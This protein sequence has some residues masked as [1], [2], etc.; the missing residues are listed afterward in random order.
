MSYRLVSN[1]PINNLQQ[2]YRYAFIGFLLL[3]VFW[4][5]YLFNDQKKVTIIDTK[6]NNNDN[7]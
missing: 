5:Y 3:V 2:Y 4:L 1:N 6:Y 7:E